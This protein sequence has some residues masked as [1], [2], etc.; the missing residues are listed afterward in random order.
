MASKY[1]QIKI[2]EDGHRILR[3][4]KLEY[5]GYIGEANL[6]DG[7]YILELCKIAND[8]IKRSKIQVKK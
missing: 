4:S 7:K 8:L 2:S 6:A 3:Q 1:K 5:M